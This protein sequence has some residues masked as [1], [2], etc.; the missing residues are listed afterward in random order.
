[1]KRDSTKKIL[2]ALRRV[3]DGRVYVSENFAAAMAEKMVGIPARAQQ[4]ARSPGEL[5]SDRELEVFRFLG[6]GRGTPQIAET[7]GISLKTV[8]AYCARI[9]EKLGVA[10]ATELLREAVRFEEKH[11]AN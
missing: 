7:L 3:L 1:M 2:V 9:K 6:Q 5:L 8:Q 11:S 10:S 4:P